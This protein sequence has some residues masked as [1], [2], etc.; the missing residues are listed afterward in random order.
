MLTLKSVQIK[1]NDFANTPGFPE[2]WRNLD[3][4]QEFFQGKKNCST[5]PGFPGPVATLKENKLF[6]LHYTP[7]E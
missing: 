5:F 4:F 3:I 6:C 7:G 2:K 1:T